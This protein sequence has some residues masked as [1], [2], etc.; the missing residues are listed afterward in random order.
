MLNGSADVMITQPSIDIRQRYLLMDLTPQYYDRRV[1][2]ALRRPIP[3]NTYY[4]L[5]RPYDVPTWIFVGVTTVVVYLT[6]WAIEKWHVRRH[7]SHRRSSPY[8]L[9]AAVSVSLVGESV[10]ASWFSVRH[11]AQGTLI[12]FIWLPLALILNNAYESILLS[13]L[14]SVSYEKSIDTF[15]ELHKQQ[16]PLYIRANTAMPGIMARHRRKDIRQ[17]YQENVL[18]RGGLFHYDQTPSVSRLL[19][20]GKAAVVATQAVINRYS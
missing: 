4:T 5:L 15:K 8:E 20:E 3:A 6:L 17:A 14:V 7:P 10:P 1:S 9:V 12:L 11:V 16:L 19:H 2:F 13:H 18:E